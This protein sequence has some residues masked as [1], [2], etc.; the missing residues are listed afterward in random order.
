MVVI[1][2][3]QYVFMLP[4]KPCVYMYLLLNT[5]LNRSC[6]HKTGSAQ[7]RGPHCPNPFWQTA[8]WPRIDIHAVYRVEAYSL[9]SYTV[10]P[11]RS[12]QK[13]FWI[14][15]LF[16]A[17]H[18]IRLSFFLLFFFYYFYADFQLRMSFEWKQKVD[19]LHDF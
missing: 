2:T 8:C 7:A 11:K 17:R 14:L 12:G 4:E 9:S 1:I 19:I 18:C 10:A 3:I 15:C 16:L 6:F 13:T 5:Y